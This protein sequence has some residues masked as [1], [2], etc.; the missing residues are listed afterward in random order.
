MRIA[1]CDDDDACIVQLENLLKEFK[2]NHTKIEW[3][4]FYSAEELLSFYRHN[5]GQFDILITDIEMNKINGVELA[6]SLREVDSGLVIIF[7]TSHDK[8]IRQCFRSSPL[9]FWDKPISRHVFYA[10]MKDAINRVEKNKKSFGFK[11]ENIYRR[12]SYSDIF[13]FSTKGKRII[14][15]S[16]TGVCEFT[17]SFKL[18]EDQWVDAGFIQIS[19]FD[20]VNMEYIDKFVANE[21]NIYLTN[22]ECLKVS[23]KNIQ[24]IKSAFFQNDFEHTKQM[25]KKL[26][27]TEA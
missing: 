22:G 8:Y 6:N 18:Y 19:R 4:C 25:M 11:H 23:R 20:F 16:N 13:Y 3:E 24:K 17:G 10:D 5:G 27:D 9:A 26:L 12:I 14:I 7:I 1:I 2:Y 15:H 21:E